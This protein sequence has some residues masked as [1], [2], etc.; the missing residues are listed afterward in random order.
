MSVLELE[1]MLYQW[2]STAA[3][4]GDGF[5]VKTR[6]D[7]CLDVIDGVAHAT[8]FGISPAGT[9][10]AT[11]NEYRRREAESDDDFQFIDRTEHCT[12][13]LYRADGEHF[14]PTTLGERWVG[15]HSEPLHLIDTE[16]NNRVYNTAFDSREQ[17]V[18]LMYERGE[19]SVRRE[20]TDDVKAAVGGR[21]R[22]VIS[23]EQES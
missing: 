20:P 11:I 5:G 22:P 10:K 4:L 15:H 3:V 14:L 16:Q 7:A 13:S 17:G 19:Q 21:Y 12:L 8:K 9:I 2:G 23:V 18:L 1:A 6:H